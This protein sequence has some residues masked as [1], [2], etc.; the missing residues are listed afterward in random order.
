MPW[1]PE[2][3]TAP[4]AETRRAQEDTRVNDAIHH[5]EGIMAD[6]PDA[7][8]RSF[9]GQPVLDDPRV[10]QVEGECR[11]GRGSCSPAGR[12]STLE[13]YVQTLALTYC[14]TSISFIQ[15]ESALD[16]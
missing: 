14:V 8:I 6:E 15:A 11:R 7:L 1:M 9:A 5:Y 13:R 12:P 10:S 16:R 2:V 3:L 4:I